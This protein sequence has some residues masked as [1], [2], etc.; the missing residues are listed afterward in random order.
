MA[1]ANKTILITGANTGIGK[2]TAQA[3]AQLGGT[4]VSASPRIFIAARSIEK[5]R[6]VIDEII[7][8][9]GNSK[10]EFLHLE[11]DDLNSVAACAHTFGAMKLPLDILINNAGLARAT[12]VTKQGFEST[13]GVNHLGHF[14][15]TLLLKNALWAAPEARV[16]TV[17]SAAHARCNGIVFDKLREPRS[18]L[19]GWPEYSVSKLANVLF[20]KELA[21]RWDERVH[22]Y[23]VHPGVIASDIWRMLPW[24]I[25]PLVTATMRSVEEGAHASVHCATSPAVAHQS[26]LYYGEL[27]DEKRS[28]KLSCDEALAAQLWNKSLEWVSPWL[29]DES[30]EK[31]RHHFRDT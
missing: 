13:F 10:I 4:D 17:A 12:G 28:S 23:A 19:T 18:S 7:L 24:P 1:L 22:T 8:A 30:T 14:L 21:R 2:A 20:S 9:S 6:P 31:L 25:R 11:L 27:G 26:G 3:L 5:T 29:A 15:L 16:V